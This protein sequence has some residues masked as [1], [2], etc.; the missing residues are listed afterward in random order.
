MLDDELYSTDYMTA[1][2]GDTL[3]GTADYVS[4][5]QDNPLNPQENS[6]IVTNQEIIQKEQRKG[7]FGFECGASKFSIKITNYFSNSLHKYQ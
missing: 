2:F 5:S 7:N 6:E 1:P 4:G 3:T